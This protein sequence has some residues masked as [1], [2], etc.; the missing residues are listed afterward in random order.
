[1]DEICLPWLKTLDAYLNSI[2]IILF[3][4]VQRAEEPDV[5]ANENAG[6]DK[7]DG[8]VPG[9]SVSPTSNSQL[10]ATAVAPSTLTMADY[11][12]TLA[13]LRMVSEVSLSSSLSLFYLAIQFIWSFLVN[14]SNFQLHV[15]LRTYGLEQMVQAASS[16][17]GL[18]TIKRV[19]QTLQDLGVCLCFLFCLTL[20]I[21]LNH[22]AY[23]SPIDRWMRL[24]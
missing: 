17:V 13:S 3:L 22:F 2:F 5:S 8:V 19:E 24:N 7:A 1:M 10:P 16:A 6:L 21:C 14:L 20:S 23:L 15:Y 9:R 18:R 11:A 12:S 4:A